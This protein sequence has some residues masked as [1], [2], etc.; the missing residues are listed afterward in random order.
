MGRSFTPREHHKADLLYQLS[1]SKTELIFSKDKNDDVFVL[2]DPMS[3]ISQMFPNLSF[4]LGEDKIADLL[5]YTN[6]SEE[7]IEKIKEIENDLTIVIKNDDMIKIPPSNWYDRPGFDKNLKTVAMWYDG[8]LDKN[9]YYCDKN[10]ELFLEFIKDEI[11][12]LNKETDIDI[13]I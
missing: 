12:N 3:E 6:K 5:E 8:K 11:L 10:N 13:E 7:S 1:S 9:F 2:Y 4:L